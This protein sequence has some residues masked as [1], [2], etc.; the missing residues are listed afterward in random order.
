MTRFV[1]R[2]TAGRSEQFVRRCAAARAELLK[3]I[4]DP[5]RVEKA[6]FEDIVRPGAQ[7]EFGRQHGFDAIR[8]VEDYRQ[9]VPIRTYEDLEPW[10]RRI[11]NGRAAVLTRE[12]PYQFLKT[13]GTM[14]AAKLIPKT[15]HWRLKYR[16]PAIY[17]QWGTYLHYHPD[18]AAH[19]HAVMDLSWE[20]DQPREFVGE[21]PLQAITHRTASLGKTDWTPSWYDSPWFRFDQDTVDYLNRV[22]LRLRHFVGRDLRGIVSVNPSTLIALSNHL[23]VT[24][25][26]LIEDLWTGTLFGIRRFKP[27]TTLARRLERLLAR[28][29]RLTIKALWPNL[30]L[31]VCW[32]SSTASLYLSELAE[33]YPDAEVL[34]FSTTGTEGVV[35]LPI[36]RHPTSGVLAVNQGVYEFL[37]YDPTEEASLPRGHRSTCHF[38]ELEVG[39][40]YRLV[41]TQANGLYRYLVGDLYKVLGYVGRVPRLEFVGREGHF[42][43]FT[44]EKLTETQVMKAGQGAMDRLELHYQTFTCCPVWGQPPH[45]A[46]LVEP[47]GSW[48]PSVVARLEEELDVQLGLANCEYGG[49]RASKR[50]ARARVIVVEPGMFQRLWDARVSGGGVSSAQLKHSCLQKDARLLDEIQNLA[51]AIPAALT[52]V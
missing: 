6:V 10:I 5:E 13:S 49:K 7:T 29:G 18:L 35:T 23:A 22:Y 14:G 44:G 20:R 52:A 26:R 19:P 31:L 9:A 16:G 46:F 25:Q 43:S 37:P 24:S 36:D 3:A 40:T 38:T 39:K 2:A 17:A 42:S 27:N 15:R 48:R 47:R 8:T 32:K 1:R 50:L 30:H 4:D 12:A 45:Y 11:V 33:R 41:M 51:R 28:D 21:I 34:P